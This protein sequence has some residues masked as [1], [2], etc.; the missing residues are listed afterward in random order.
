MV[1]GPSRKRIDEAVNELRNLLIKNKNKKVLVAYVL[2]G[3]GIVERGTQS[4]VLNEF[5]K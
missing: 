2:A 1:D 5:D 3:H 4:V